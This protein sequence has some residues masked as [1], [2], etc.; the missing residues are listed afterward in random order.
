[1]LGWAKKLYEDDKVLK[2]AY[3]LEENENLDGIVV[4][5]KST[6][7]WHVEKLATGS[8]DYL[9]RVFCCPLGCCVDYGNLKDTKTC[10]ASG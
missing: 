8:T 10:V 3:S 9:T 2:V 1:M 7:D 5:D 4:R 6:C